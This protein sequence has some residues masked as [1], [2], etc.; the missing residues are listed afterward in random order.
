MSDDLKTAIVGSGN[1]WT[2]VY[3]ELEKHGVA[4]VG[5]RVSGIGVGGLTTGGSKTR[6]VP[7]SKY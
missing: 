4:A 3:T 7:M 5:G 6:Q 2:Q 1:V